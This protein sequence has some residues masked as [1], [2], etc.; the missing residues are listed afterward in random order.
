MLIPNVVKW[1]DAVSLSTWFRIAT[2]KI[3]TYLWAFKYP[4]K[5]NS[6]IF[7]FELLHSQRNWQHWTYWRAHIDICD[8]VLNLAFAICMKAYTQHCTHKASIALPLSKIPSNDHRSHFYAIFILPLILLSLH[9]V[10]YIYFCHTSAEI[11][12][13]FSITSLNWF[14]YIC[15]VW[16]YI[17]VRV[18]VCLLCANIVKLSIT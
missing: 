14:S 2:R 15:V 4:F 1:H 13:P 8:F 9:Y 18:C 10:V 16:M 6:I 3:E 11:G 12:G 5:W 17:C 7:C